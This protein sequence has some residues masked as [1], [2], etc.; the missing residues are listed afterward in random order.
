MKKFD[1]SAAEAEPV[2]LKFPYWSGMDDSSAR[3]TADAAFHFC[4]QYRAMFP[5]LAQRWQSQRPQKSAVEFV[6]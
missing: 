1:E 6:L 4:E 5:G 2:E 3:V